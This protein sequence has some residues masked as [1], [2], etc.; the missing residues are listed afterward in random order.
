MTKFTN[1]TRLQLEAL[2]HRSTPSGFDTLAPAAFIGLDVAVSRFIPTDPIRV[3]PV[4]TLNYG[5]GSEALP[6]LHGL[7]NAFARL[8][9]GNPVIPPNPI[10]VSPVFFGLAGES[11]VT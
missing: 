9:P 4:F 11:P 7:Q 1:R 3:A 8:I 5:S 6:S 2:E 10:Q